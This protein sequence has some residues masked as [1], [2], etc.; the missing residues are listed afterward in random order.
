MDLNVQMSAVGGMVNNLLNL[1]NK[2]LGMY[3]IPPDPKWSPGGFGGAV[4]AG[5]IRAPVAPGPK[6]AAKKVTAVSVAASGEILWKS[7]LY[8]AS[9][10][11]VKRSLGKD[12]FIFS[13]Q[14]VPSGG[15]ICTVGS[16]SFLVRE[17][18]S[19]GPCAS[20]KLAE[21]SAAKAALQAEFPEVFRELSMGIPAGVSAQGQNAPQ[22][23]KR[24]AGG[25]AAGP[26]PGKG[27][28]GHL[29][30]IMLSRPVTKEDIVYTTMES[31]VGGTKT[32]QS[33]VALPSYDASQMFRGVPAAS[34][35]DAENNAA[36]AAVTG[37]AAFAAPLLEEHKAKKARKHAEDVEKM[38]QKHAEKQA[39]IITA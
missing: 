21:H 20:K 6:A 1:R 15:Y 9:V 30:A 32:Y 22:G 33:S 7:K 4:A 16:P 19:E 5:G 37:L 36:K 12:D 2:L 38:K 11:K 26:A 31:E 14:D 25:A 8:E 17:Y 39:A 13:T 29:I 27:E 35:K 3:G 28:L 23:Q 34:K 24:K 10:K 18:S